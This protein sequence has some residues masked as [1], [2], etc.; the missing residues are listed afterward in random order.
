M[1]GGDYTG[2]GEETHVSILD[3]EIEKSII[4]TENKLKK[5]FQNS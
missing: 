1:S 2:E 4:K 5:I 3:K